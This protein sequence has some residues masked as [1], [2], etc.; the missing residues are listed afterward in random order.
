MAALLL[1]KFHQSGG[2][3]PSTHRKLGSCC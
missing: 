2:Y 3:R 1:A